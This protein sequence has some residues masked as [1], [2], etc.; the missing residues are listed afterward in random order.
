MAVIQ[1]L[2]HE[3]LDSAKREFDKLLSS[4]SSLENKVLQPEVSSCYSMNFMC[5]RA[6]A[7]LYACVSEVLALPRPVYELICTSLHYEFSASKRGYHFN[8][9]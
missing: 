6:R 2:Q 7:Y 9:Q 8:T 4:L 5:V 1:K 3:A